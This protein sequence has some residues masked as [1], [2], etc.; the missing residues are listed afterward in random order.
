MIDLDFEMET[1]MRVT[2]IQD[3]LL[4]AGAKGIVFGAS[5]GKD[6]ALVGI[7]C[8]MAH[9]N[10]LGVIMPCSS[11]LNYTKDRDD[12]ILV[13]EQF[14]IKHIEVDLT[15]TK[16][17]LVSAIG[18]ELSQQA[19]INIAPRLRM[20]TLYAIAANRGSVVAGTSNR[21]EIYMGYFTKWGDGASDFNP[22]FDLTATEV[23]AFLEYLEVD[24]RI[25][26]KAPSASLFEGQTDEADMGISYTEIDE[27][28][29][30]STMGDNYHIIE[31]YHNA[32]RH[33]RF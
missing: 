7:L 10:T 3:F 24:E 21:S 16:S 14:G 32:S 28:L 6:S 33:K 23:H 30:T 12:A 5:G 25:Y 27:F 17:S 18:M 2:Q 4:K 11:S 9:R 19:D 1:I 29:L 15:P 22:I 20:A 8:R 13:A 26:K 31:K